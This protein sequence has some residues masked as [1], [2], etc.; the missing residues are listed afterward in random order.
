[1]PRDLRQ[2]VAAAD[3]A[4]EDSTAWLV[5]FSDLCL[6]LFA[7]VLVA[8]VVSSARLK[9]VPPA[10]PDPPAAHEARFEPPPVTAPPDEPPPPSPLAALGQRLEDALAASGSDAVTVTTTDAAVVITLADTVTFASGKA[11]LLPDAAAVFDK[12]RP[13]LQVL[14]EFE[15]DV[16][17][18]TDDVPIHTAAFPS[19]LELSLARAARVANELAAGDPGLRVRTRAAGFGEHRPVA[20]NIDDA[21]RARNRRVEIRLTPRR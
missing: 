8:L 3:P 17:G 4:E 9:L 21:G 14:P 5:T 1:M 20:P 6:Q 10:A 13:L 12:V 19:N 16:V 11:E 2:L 15:I 7:F 18:H